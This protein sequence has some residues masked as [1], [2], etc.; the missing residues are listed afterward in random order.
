MT[1]E[2]IRCAFCRSENVE[3]QVEFFVPINTEP[4]KDDLADIFEGVKWMDTYWCPDC[5][6]KTKDT[7]DSDREKESELEILRAENE[8]LRKRIYADLEELLGDE[9]ER[10]RVALRQACDDLEGYIDH[11][12]P[13]S[14]YPDQMR[15]RER[16][17]KILAG[18]REALGEGE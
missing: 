13:V 9:N 4:T 14:E 18:Y 3:Q 1:I 6:K 7:G 17:A 12:Y 15:R 5:G 10:L 2:R 11:H 8:R 16:E